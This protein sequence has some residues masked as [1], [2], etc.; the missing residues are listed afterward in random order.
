MNQTIEK[1]NFSLSEVNQS[2]DGFFVR[3]LVNKSGAWSQTLYDKNGKPFI[4]RVMPNVFARAL[5]R[6]KDVKLLLEH[7]KNV[8]LARTKDETLKLTETSRGLEMEANLVPS[9]LSEHIHSSIKRGTLSDMSFGMIV[10]DEE[11]T[12]ENG[13]DK[14]SITDLALYECS[15]V[16][17]GA[18]E[19]GSVE[20]RSNDI[21]Q[22]IEVPNFKERGQKIMKLDSMSTTQLEERKQELLSEADGIEQSKETEQRSFTP[23]EQLRQETILGEI[24]KINEQIALKNKTQRNGEIIMNNTQLNKE[25]ELRGMEQ[26]LRREHGEEVRAMQ[27]GMEP[28]KILMP[29]HLSNQ[30]VEKLNEYAPIF[31]R[32]RNFTPVNGF[33]EILREDNIG[34]AG[35]V[36]ES[37]SLKTSDFSM[38]KIRLDQKRAGTA[39]E[40]SQQ[41]VNDSGI[42]IVGYTTNI[43]SRRLGLTLDGSVLIGDKATQFEGIL[44][45]DVTISP[46]ETQSATGITIDELFELQLSMHPSYVSGAVWVVSRATFNMIAKLKD[47]NG[48]FYLVRDVAETG[49]TYRL[50]GQ[51]VL[52]NDV[53]PNPTAGEKAVLFVNFYE[54]Y[55]TMTKK[56]MG[57]KIIDGDTQNALAGTTTLMLDVFVDGK[58]LNPAAIQILKMK[59]A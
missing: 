34:S 56:G 23:S 37:S 44:K 15:I 40:L 1:R 53:M 25:Q 3:G 4:E 12:Q 13:I 19:D 38:N 42:D 2:S 18:Y 36:G 55:A 52:V 30:I 10:L 35:F 51:T 46:Q 8:L 20:A 16:S 27:T 22:N 49:V 47:A 43:L 14:R 32:T 5:Q 39:I 7:D 45:D 50:F 59:S 29:T 31:A 57:L 26:F 58:I 48:N 24:R 54:A 41:L 11:W 17:D 6:A 28:G 33:L 9:K 21:R